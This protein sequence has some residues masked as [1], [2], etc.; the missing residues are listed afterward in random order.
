MKHLF[1][2]MAVVIFTAGS[3]AFAQLSF[4]KGNAIAKNPDTVY[5]FVL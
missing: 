2:V 5:W 4:K 3:P 1:M